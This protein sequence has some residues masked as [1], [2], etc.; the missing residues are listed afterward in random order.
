MLLGGVSISTTPTSTDDLVA[1]RQRRADSAK[2]ILDEILI[3]ASLGQ[4]RICKVSTLRHAFRAAGKS[5]SPELK[6]VATELGRV[7]VTVTPIDIQ[8]S[9][10]VALGLAAGHPQAAGDIQESPVITVST[11]T[12]GHV[13]HEE[14]LEATSDFGDGIRWFTVGAPTTTSN[15]DDRHRW[16]QEVFDALAPHCDGLELPMV[17]DLLR[18]DAQPKVE[19]YGNEEDGIRSV[20]VPAIIAREGIA[21]A[22]AS[23]GVRELTYELVESIVST[24]WIITAWHSTTTHA[25]R[26]EAT[27]GDP[28]ARE[29]IMAHVRYRWQRFGGETAGDLG[30][31]LARS[32]VETYDASHRM[33]E[34]WV[35]SW[36]FDFFQSLS[37]SSAEAIETA[38][39]QI[40][41]LLS[42][43]GEFRRRLKALKDAEGATSDH[44][45]YPG[46]TRR[47][48]VE[49]KDSV[50]LLGDSLALADRKFNDL[51]ESIRA[52]MDLLM[53]RSLGVQQRL[54]EV[55]QKSNDRLQRKLAQVTALILVPTL[56]AGIYGANTQ[57]PGGDSW[58][59]FELM[60][61]LMVTSAAL[62]YLYMRN[63][64]HDREDSAGNR[65]HDPR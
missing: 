25:G 59:G 39:L 49:E 2:R 54:N 55:Q 18:I 58:I 22:D 44:S 17:Q 8:R 64:F 36:Q 31:L 65:L 27:F 51:L 4:T 6:E 21:S 35:V 16:A 28:L 33:L 24:R 11:W 42:M 56:I 3:A 10:T 26:S 37:A 20:S 62:V 47:Q 40:S 46:V 53:L 32:L 19:P 9:G 29:P 50:T 5:A 45:W 1:K 61:F 15:D 23:K 30:V 43:V 7:G 34:G 52:D 63:Y 60:L 38:T 57:L 12:P 13:S 41:D 14:P 48:D